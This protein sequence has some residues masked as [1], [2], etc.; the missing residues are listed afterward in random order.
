MSYT[1]AKIVCRRCYAVLDADDAYC[2]RCG[3][4]TSRNDLSAPQAG[5]QAAGSPAQTARGTASR[6]PGQPD[7]SAADS[8]RGHSADAPRQAAGKHAPKL[9]SDSIQD[10]PWVVLALLFLVLG[11]LGLPLLWRSRAFSNTSKIIISVV[12][13]GIMV[14]AVAIIGYVLWLVVGPLTELKNAVL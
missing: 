5:S 13:V 11:P 14:L 9:F 1:I 12:L 3:A 8:Y 10:N 2:R 7:R 6:G 4:P